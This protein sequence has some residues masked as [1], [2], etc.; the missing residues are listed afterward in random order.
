MGTLDA[1]QYELSVAPPPSLTQAD[2][3]RASKISDRDVSID[4]RWDSLLVA[5]IGFTQA[6]DGPTSL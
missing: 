4:G 1:P 2:C 5:R 3:K 6:S